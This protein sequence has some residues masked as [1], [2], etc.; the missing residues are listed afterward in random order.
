SDGIGRYRQDAEAAVYFCALEALQNVAKYANAS[1]AVVR[2][3]ALDGKLCFAIADDGV[4]F[5]TSARGYGTGMQGMADRLAAL[6]GELRVRSAPDS[7]TVVEGTVPAQG[8][9]R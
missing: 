9:G 7:G 5:D 3:S 2:L 1:Q 6:G 8:A 4:G